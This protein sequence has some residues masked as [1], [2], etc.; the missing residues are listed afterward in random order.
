MEIDPFELLGVTPESSPK[1]VMRAYYDLSLIM[2]PDRGGTPHEMAVLHGAYKMVFKLITSTSSEERD[3]LLHPIP[4]YPAFRDIMDECVFD[5]KRFN[6]EFESVVTTAIGEHYPAS[7]P[8]GYDG[9]WEPQTREPEAQ[10]DAGGA[11]RTY[12]GGQLPIYDAAHRHGPWNKVPQAL[13]DYTVN[14]C[15]L[16]MGDCKKVYCSNHV[17][18]EKDLKHK[19]LEDIVSEREQ[20]YKELQGT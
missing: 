8:G 15:P 13:D 1:E 19:M 17:I 16:Y 5:S 14:V 4:E 11:M 9:D 20:H 18:A 10:D 3:K 6:R 12:D 7:A 2:H